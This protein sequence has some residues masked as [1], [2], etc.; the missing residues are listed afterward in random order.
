MVKEHVGYVMLDLRAAQMEAHHQVL[1][2]CDRYVILLTVAGSDLSDTD[3]SHTALA[4]TG[5]VYYSS[6]ITFATNL[7]DSKHSYHRQCMCGQL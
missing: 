4:H 6:F 3:R 1:C 7:E 5:M 2:V